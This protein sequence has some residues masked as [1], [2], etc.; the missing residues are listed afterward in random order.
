MF[1]FLRFLSKQAAQIS[2]ELA[3][4]PQ[5]HRGTPPR[6]TPHGRDPA[7]VEDYTGGRGLQ[8]QEEEE[9]EEEEEEQQQ[10]PKTLTKDEVE[11]YGRQLILPE[12]SVEGQLRL[13][14]AKVLVVG[15]GG[16]GCPTVM[17]LAAAGSY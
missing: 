2:E 14:D 17:F 13:R 11:R 4:E 16:L 12:L 1:L 8:Q 10:R 9:E 5:P 7:P 3:R 6:S 15:A